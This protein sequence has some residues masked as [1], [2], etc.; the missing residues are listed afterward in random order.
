MADHE[1]LKVSL[2]DLLWEMAAIANYTL[3]RAGSYRLCP[4]HLPLRT[5]TLWLRL[6]LSLL[7]F[8]YPFLHLFLL[9]FV[10]RF[11]P[12]PFLI[13]IHFLLLLILSLSLICSL[14][15]LF[16]LAS[17]SQFVS[18]FS[19]IVHDDAADNDVALE[20]AIAITTESP[21]CVARCW[22]FSAGNGLWL[23]KGNSMNLF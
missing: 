5:L 6:S 12:F 13:L 20:S 11:S 7:L 10:I 22:L 18:V 14:Y 9:H 1:S 19:F 17:P 8:L 2:I 15:P 3:Q 23:L 16:R 21:W 4:S